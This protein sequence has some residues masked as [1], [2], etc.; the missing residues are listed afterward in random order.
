MCEGMNVVGCHWIFTIKY[1]P[2]G[3]ID[4]YKARLV[5]KGYHQQ[6]GIDYT[7]TF[8]PVIKPTT[9]RIVLWL[10][11]SKS[12]QYG[13]LISILPFSKVIFKK[14]SSYAATRFC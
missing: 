1:H 8:S 5:A 4:R 14:K 10:A 13:K 9:I 11:V 3:E 7:E 2:N 12:S 6:Q